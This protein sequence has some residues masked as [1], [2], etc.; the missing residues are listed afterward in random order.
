MQ[1]EV[2]EYDVNSPLLRDILSPKEESKMDVRQAVADLVE[3]RFG[4]DG[5][6]FTEDD[7]GK[8][9][10]RVATGQ[11]VPVR[12]A[13][14]A[15]RVLRYAPAEAVLVALQDELREWRE[16]EEERREYLDSVSPLP[17]C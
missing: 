4:A 3:W 5:S 6:G 12:G 2:R 17:P 1:V 7:I 15:A 11:Q 9:V 14:E 16:A 13:E 10:C 8:Y